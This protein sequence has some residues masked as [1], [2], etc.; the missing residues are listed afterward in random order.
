M[1]TPPDHSRLPFTS[2]PKI[3]AVRLKMTAFKAVISATPLMRGSISDPEGHCLSETLS[4]HS[5]PPMDV[6]ERWSTG[7][8]SRDPCQCKTFAPAVYVSPANTSTLSQVS[9]TWRIWPPGCECQFVL[10]VRFAR[11]ARASFESDPVPRQ[12]C[13][14]IALEAQTWELN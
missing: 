2:T 8:P 6:M 13:D 1:P 9:R 3:G 14:R 4:P 12:A 11:P 10:Q 7:D 5:A